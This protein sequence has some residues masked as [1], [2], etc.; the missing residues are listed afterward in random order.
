MFHKETAAPLTSCLHIHV[1]D[2]DIQERECFPLLRAW[3]VDMSDNG[4]ASQAK[5]TDRPECCGC[6]LQ[7]SCCLSRQIIT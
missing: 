7:L 1:M 2:P 5:T 4:V 3:Q 6:V